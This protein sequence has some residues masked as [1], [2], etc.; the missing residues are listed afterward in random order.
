[1]NVANTAH[2]SNSMNEGK[3]QNNRKLRWI[4]QDFT[5][6][7]SNGRTS[8]SSCSSY[9]F[10]YGRNTTLACDMFE[11]SSQ[12]VGKWEYHHTLFAQSDEFQQVHVR[13]FIVIKVRCYILIHEW[14]CHRGTLNSSAVQGFIQPVIPYVWYRRCQVARSWFHEHINFS[15]D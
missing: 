7:S 2:N 6:D 4:V 10:Y 9:D 1:M 8:G 14:K 11:N 5:S 15:K 12:A 3:H 13:G